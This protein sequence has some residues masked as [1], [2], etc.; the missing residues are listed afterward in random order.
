M[1]DYYQ[2]HS[3][4]FHHSITRYINVDDDNQL[5]YLIQ[6][7]EVLRIFQDSIHQ[8]NSDRQKNVVHRNMRLYKG[9]FKQKIDSCQ[10]KSLL[11]TLVM[12]E[13]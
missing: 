8:V 12:D 6:D 11:L 7:T 1:V 3:S 4:Q 5:S 10:N 2:Y 9:I 13:R